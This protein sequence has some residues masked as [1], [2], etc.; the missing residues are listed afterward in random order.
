M[1]LINASFCGKKPTQ[2]SVEGKA[3]LYALQTSQFMVGMSYLVSIAYTSRKS[4]LGLYAT[5]GYYCR[6]SPQYSSELS[7]DWIYSFSG[8]QQVNLK[9]CQNATWI[10]STWSLEGNGILHNASA[11][12]VTGQDFQLYPAMEGHSVSTIDYRDDIR[13]L[14]IEPVTYQEVQIVQGR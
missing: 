7:Q 3:L 10:T 13:V 9:C 5:G 4:K 8:K 6:T 14:H 2:R 1:T 11:C 12:H